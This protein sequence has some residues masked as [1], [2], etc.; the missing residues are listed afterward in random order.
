MTKERDSYYNNRSHHKDIKCQ[1]CDKKGH[2]VAQCWER[3]N[4]AFSDLNVIPIWGQGSRE[5]QEHL[6]SKKRERSGAIQDENVRVLPSKTSIAPVKSTTVNPDPA[7]LFRLELCGILISIRLNLDFSQIMF[8]SLLID[9]P[10]KCACFVG[11]LMDNRKPKRLKD[12]LSFFQRPNEPHLKTYPSTW[13]GGQYRKF[14]S[15]WFEQWHWLEYSI[16]K[17]KAYCFACFLFETESSKGSSFT[18][19]GFSSWRN[20]KDKK[21]GILAHIGG[22]NSIHSVS[23]LKW[24]NLRNPSRHIERVIKTMS[25][26]EV[27]ENR[28][29]LIATIEAVKL[30]AA[31]G[32]PFRGHDESMDSLNRGNFD[33]ILKLMKQMSLATKNAKYTSSDI[34]KQI[35]NILGNKVRAKIREE[36]G[37]SKFCILADE[38]LDTAN[39]EKMPSFFILWI[40]RGWLENNFSNW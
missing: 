31:Q 18:R 36:I 11:V 20:V 10:I 5:R 22:L 16:E 12:I 6:R 19:D 33:A 4:K 23:M 9:L 2:S 15:S 3:F 39:K 32:C 28:L 26:N 21:S 24:E 27:A 7:Y 29:R 17:D 13:D 25:A 30:L 35:A 14:N 37:E 8:N 38:A 34:Q 1:I 40:V